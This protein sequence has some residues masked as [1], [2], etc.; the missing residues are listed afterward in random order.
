[1]VFFLEPVVLSWHM[2]LLVLVR[3]TPLWDQKS[4]FCCITFIFRNEGIVPRA[5]QHIISGMNTMEFKERYRNDF[6]NIGLEMSFLEDYQDNIYD[7]LSP[8]PR[9]GMNTKPS[10]EIRVDQQ[11]INRV[12]RLTVIL[13]QNLHS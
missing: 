2:V 8:S 12:A 5:L 9:I 6:N 7:L 13:I 3:P 1:M 10:L 4:L 11:N